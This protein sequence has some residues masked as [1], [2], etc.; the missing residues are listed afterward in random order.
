MNKLVSVMATYAFDTG[1]DRADASLKSQ[2]APKFAQGDKVGATSLWNQAVGKN[3]IDTSDAEALIYLE[4]QRVLASGSPYITLVVG[5]MLTGDAGTI[6]TGRDDLQGAYVAQKEYNDGVK[7]SGGRLVR[8]LVAN[9]GSKSDYVTEVAG[10]I[11]QAA[12][13]GFDH[14]WCDGLAL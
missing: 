8:L 3:G 7:L 11:V 6:S 14:C 4:D 9:A 2:A 12:E 10:Q 5:T 13:A 1:T